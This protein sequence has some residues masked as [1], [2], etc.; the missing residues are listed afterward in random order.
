MYVLHG[1]SKFTHISPQEGAAAWMD[2][3]RLFIYLQISRA[4]LTFW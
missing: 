3:L 1:H 2:I 4:E